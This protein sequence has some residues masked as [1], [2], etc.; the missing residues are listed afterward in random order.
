MS[1][2]DEL[3][4]ELCPNGVEYKSIEAVTTMHRGVRVVK[5]E[6][7]PNGLYPVYQNSLTPLGYMNEKNCDAGTTFVISAG[8]AGEVG[9]STVDFWAADDC[10]YFDNNEFLD[11]SY[12]YHVL[13][14]KQYYLFSQV[15]KASIPRLGRGIIEKMIISVPPLEIQREIVRI[16][17]NFTELTAE[18][19]AELIAR[20]KQYSY[21]RDTL[22]SFDNTVKKVKLK[23]IAVDIYRGSGIKRE[24]VTETGISCVRYGEIYTTYNTWFDTCV[25]HTKLEY[26]S[27]P[28]YFEHGDILFA[29]TGESVEDIA[30][31]VAYIGNEK[32]L[33]GGDI[34][35]LKHN[36]EPRYL[37][38]VL[39]TYKARQQKSKGKI[40]SKVVHS[41][42]PAIEEIEIPLPSM[43]VQRRYADVLDNFE[44]IC[45]DLNIGLPAEIEA[46]KKQYEY[47]R[48]VLLTFAECGETILDRQTDR[49]TDELNGL[50][51]LCQYVFGFVSVT[52]NMISENHDSK[53]KPITSGNREAGEYPYYGASGIVDYV[54]G[55][56]FDGDYLL[57][58]EDGNNLVARS[59]PI[60]FSISG[61]N[62]VNNHAHVLKFDCYA[63]RR[64][65]EFYLNAIDLSQFISGGAQPKL[66]QKNL[67]TIPIP[68]PAIK[69]QE[70]IVGILDRFDALCNDISS[71]L[72]AEIE[73]RTKQ[74][75]YYRDK[76]LTFE[77]A[78]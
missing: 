9:F 45:N 71:G 25:S 59:T 70:R 27:N 41:S 13:L 22:L 67:N 14:S 5:R 32:C 44:K 11:G 35:V 15:R 30:K 1:K 62:W 63:T 21:Y 77:P 49:Q 8:A 31:S 39:S 57:V 47:Y 72:P 7:E 76:L 6:L 52:L 38:H 3:I 48:D 43:E 29:I 28:K 46:R 18:L 69:E 20:K 37:A 73:A 50:I 64:Y 42:V 2:L 4:K 16:L 17:D 24:E 34:V 75:E 53:R 54:S 55:Y 12:L 51:L 19:T 66:N 23:D 61:K 10:Y 65:V 56:I 74:Y 40:K 68:L 36:Q 26:V 33:A 78:K 60:A 58:S